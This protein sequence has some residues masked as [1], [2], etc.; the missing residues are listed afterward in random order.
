MSGPHPTIMAALA[1]H[2][3]GAIE[4]RRAMYVAGLRTM[5]WQFEYSDDARAYRAGKAELE[6][7]RAEQRD[8]DPF[9]VLWNRHAHPS[10]FVAPTGREVKA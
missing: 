1:P 2:I 5:D 6:R 8:I 7:L 4:V 9:A 3:N 10:Y